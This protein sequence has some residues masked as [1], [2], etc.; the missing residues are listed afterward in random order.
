MN[1]NSLI[2]I[3]GTA[4]ALEPIHHGGEKSGGTISEIRRELTRVGD[5][6]E[7][8]PVISAN[9]IAGTLRDQCA[10][11]CLDQ[12]N[13]PKFHG[14]LGLRAFDLLTSG[15]GRVAKVNGKKKDDGQINLAA[16]KELRDLFP[17]ISLFGGSIGNRMLRGRLGVKNWV[18]LCDEMK[19]QLPEEYHERAARVHIE[20]LLFEAQFSTRDDKKNLLWQDRIAPETLSTWLAENEKLDQANEAKNKPI[21]MKYAMEALATGTEFYVRFWLQNPS[22][23]DLGAFFGALTYFN[24]MPKIGG[25]GNRGF[26]EVRL[27]LRQYEITG[28]SK[29]ENALAQETITQAAEHLQTQRERIIQMIEGGL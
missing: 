22:A 1:K 20:D 15:G 2:V 9:S 21:S 25:R 3:E 16:E 12:I 28:P 10:F 18:P 4:T 19:W 13:Y 17:V 7:Y 8:L 27:D 24:N 23:I 6:Y 29:V 11:W 14:T 5:E 26:G